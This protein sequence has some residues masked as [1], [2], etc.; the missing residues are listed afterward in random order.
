MEPLDVEKQFLDQLETIVDEDQKFEM[1]ESTVLV[2]DIFNQ[3]FHHGRHY[4]FSLAN[5]S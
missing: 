4:H 3:L 2:L 5:F 1:D